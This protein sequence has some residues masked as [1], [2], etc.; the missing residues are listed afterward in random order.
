MAEFFGLNWI[1]R[2]RRWPGAIE[3]CECQRGD[4]FQALGRVLRAPG[5]SLNRARRTFSIMGR[6]EDSSDDDLYAFFYPGT[7]RQ[8]Y[9]N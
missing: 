5:M 6:S 3:I 7:K 1:P 8:T 2:R 9:S 4:G